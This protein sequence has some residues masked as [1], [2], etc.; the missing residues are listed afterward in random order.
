LSS[1]PQELH[2]RNKLW[3][4]T[5]MR[6][7][8]THLP[9]VGTCGVIALLAGPLARL[10]INLGAWLL[11]WLCRPTRAGGSTACT[12]IC[13]PSRTGSR[14][15]TIFARSYCSAAAPAGTITPAKVWKLLRD[16]GVTE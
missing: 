9:I 15:A 7:L 5:L 11:K 16:H 2:P 12:A 13:G 8:L 14:A 3:R 10:P 6:E 4:P 1:W